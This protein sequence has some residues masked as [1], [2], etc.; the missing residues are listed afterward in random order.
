MSLYSLI[1][2]IIG[3]QSAAQKKLKKENKENTQHIMSDILSSSQCLSSIIPE[4]K[5][6]S[7]K[8][9]FKKK[10]NGFSSRG[11]DQTNSKAHS[12]FNAVS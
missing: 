4:T 3:K 6:E 10:S 1:N 9:N 7:N 8:F 11:F 2:H 5:Q 12:F